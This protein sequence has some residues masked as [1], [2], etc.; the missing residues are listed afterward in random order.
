MFS[1]Q[2]MLCPVF[3]CSLWNVVYTA[4]QTEIFEEHSL[5]PFGLFFAIMQGNNL[6]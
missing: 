6:N 1:V 4:V 5:S 3:L 2:V